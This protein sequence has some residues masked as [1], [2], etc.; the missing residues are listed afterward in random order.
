MM[1][2]WRDYPMFRLIL[3]VIYVMAVL[4]AGA[5]AGNRDS[6]LNRPADLDNRKSVIIHHGN[7]DTTVGNYNQKSGDFWLSGPDNKITTGTRDSWG[8]L[9]VN[10]YGDD[11]GD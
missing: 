10:E 1:G 4:V 2:L 9:T 5:A 3:A 11:D 6:D 8:N 7:G